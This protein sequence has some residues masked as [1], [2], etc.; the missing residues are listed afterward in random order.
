[1]KITSIQNE[2]P[3]FKRYLF[4]YSWTGKQ[5]HLSNFNLQAQG[6]SIVAIVGPV[7]SGKVV[8]YVTH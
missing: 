1:L 5:P 8:F 6:N 2:K 4:Y 7:G 3:Y